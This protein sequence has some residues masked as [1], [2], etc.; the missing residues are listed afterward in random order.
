MESNRLSTS[1]TENQHQNAEP[2]E[3]EKSAELSTEFVGRWSNLVSTTNWQKGRIISEWRE[4]LM[5]S[6]AASTAYSD[7][8]WAQ[9]VGGVTAQHV[10]R[11]RRVFDRFG[12]SYETFAGLYWSHFL[13]A[14]DWDDAEMWLEGAVQSQWSVSQMRRTRWETTGADPAVEPSEADIVSSVEDED[15]TPLAEVD[16]PT[17][18]RDGSRGVAEGPRADGPDFGDEDSV[19]S[20]Q[21]DQGDFD[22][23]LPW[24]E[25]GTPVESPFAALPS[26]PVDLAEALEQF[27]LAIIRHRADG[28]TEVDRAHVVK[29]LDALKS[30]ASL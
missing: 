23:V 13:A 21:E 30:F 9:I 17:D 10:G 26:L 3:D 25:E 12:E 4:A 19:A 7:E 18:Q 6:Q 8:A 16:E 27:K 11:L 14:L 5:G 28:W 2:A 29:A 24:E 22:D 20:G 15:F 1:V